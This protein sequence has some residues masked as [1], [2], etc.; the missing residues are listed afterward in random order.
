MT[1]WKNLRAKLNLS[2]SDVAKQLGVTRQAYANYERGVREADYNTLNKLAVIFN[3]STDYLLGRD[4]A[5]APADDKNGVWIPVLGQVQAGLPT[6]AVENIIDY[7]Q[8]SHDMSGTG[9]FFALRVKGDSME[10]KFTEGDVVIVRKQST[11]SDGDIVIALVNGD[12]ATIKKI[13][14][15]PEG[16]ILTPLNSQY[17]PMFYT[18]SEIETLPVT[19]I[20]KVVELRAKF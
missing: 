8:I 12:D 3:V 18:N 4:V 13:K 15:R 7:E 16:I 14:I 17:E 11:A 20:G 9:E 2:Q 6:T 1:E 10:P 19:I 5:S